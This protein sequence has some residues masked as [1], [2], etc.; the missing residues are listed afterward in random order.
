MIV[1]IKFLNNKMKEKIMVVK[2]HN[3]YLI[4]NNKKINKYKIINRILINKMKL[5]SQNKIIMN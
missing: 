4:N 2:F 5:I 1:K 3:I